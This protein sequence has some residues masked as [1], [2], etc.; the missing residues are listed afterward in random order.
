MTKQKKQKKGFRATFQGMSR[1]K[2]I[3]FV[4]LAVILAAAALGGLLRLLLPS[5]AAVL[6]YEGKTLREDAYAY[7]FSCY[8]YEYLV[9]Y[10][11]LG[12]EDSD[13]GWSALDEAS[14]KTYDKAFGDAIEKEIALRFVASV[15]FDKAGASLSG[16]ELS[17][18]ESTLSDMEEYSYGG[19][20]YKQLKARYGVS[21]S[22]VKRVALYEAKYKA[23]LSY[24]FG[25]DYGGV[26]AA[27]YRDELE[28]FYKAHYKRYNFVYLSDEKN[29][30]AQED[31]RAA[32]AGGIAEITFT[33]WESEYSETPVTESYPN[34]IYLYDGM[35]YD[36]AFSAELLS[37]FRTLSE[38]EVVELRNEKNDGSY[39]VMRYALDE[40]PY[41]SSDEKVQ[42]SLS[43]FA[44]YAA[45]SLYREE[46]E[47][48][49][50][51][52]EKVDTLLDKYT[53]A[54]VKKE[55]DYNLVDR[56]G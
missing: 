23:L 17:H 15:L 18:V 26:F 39:F 48:C 36:G 38:G 22:T 45:R 13:A 52:V 19:P 29:A 16:A 27:A 14:G 4:T 1:G 25:S 43:G 34:G 24:R 8:K 40:A 56:L 7:L 51:D 55:K 35:R 53:P 3:L 46:L 44:E 37:A 47:E 6:R 21:K 20:M 11:H 30:K 12:I 28:A 49:L 2:R 33:G 9:A 5:S 10:K 41:L 54:K 31:L 42:K 50:K 32:V